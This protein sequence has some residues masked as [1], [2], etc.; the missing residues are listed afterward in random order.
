MVCNWS[1]DKVDDVQDMSEVKDNKMDGEMCSESCQDSDIDG[2][3]FPRCK[4]SGDDLLLSFCG[5]EEA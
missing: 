2:S 3:E 1:G 5:V 4:G